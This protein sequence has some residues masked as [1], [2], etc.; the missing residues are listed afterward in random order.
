MD[1][2]YA[3]WGGHKVRLTWMPNQDPELLHLVTSVHGFC[4]SKGKIMLVHIKDRGFNMPG[5]H[6]DAGELPEQ[7][8]HRETLEE[9]YVKGEIKFLGAIE[10]SH[11]ENLLFD[12]NGKYPL[13]GYQLFYR[14][15]ITECL[16]FLRENEST[17][18][19]WV[20]PELVPYIMDDH[21]LSLVVLEEALNKVVSDK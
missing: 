1:Q 21:Q 16:P 11:E 7:A 8:F 9:G 14:M 18:R 4:F 3:N 15:D 19:V 5:G 20:E 10:I 6:V 17:A 2:T 13:I 12:P